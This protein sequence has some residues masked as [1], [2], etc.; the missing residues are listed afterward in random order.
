M[1]GLVWAAAN[2]ITGLRTALT[3]YTL[4]AEFAADAVAI[5]NGKGTA[6]TAVRV[7]ASG[8]LVATN[9]AA[10]QLFLTALL[11]VDA[12]L[13]LLAT[14]ARAYHVCR[15]T[16]SDTIFANLACFAAHVVTNVALLRAAKASG[17][18]AGVSCLAAVLVSTSV[19]AL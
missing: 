18:D 6:R 13:A 14:D 7:D 1:A 15:V 16:A 8:Q 9:F 4:L 5:L 19:Q 12:R 10:C 11:I 17:V 3:I 2:A